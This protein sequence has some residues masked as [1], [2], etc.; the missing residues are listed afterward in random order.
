MAKTLAAMRTQG[1]SDL[2]QTAS[3]RTAMSPASRNIY[4]TGASEA[5]EIAD[6]SGIGSLRG[7]A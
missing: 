7:S 3:C 4:R 6:L 5:E 2:D 1:D